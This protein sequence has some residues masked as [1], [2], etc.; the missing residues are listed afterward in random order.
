MVYIKSKNVC[1]DKFEWPN[2][3]G[4]I[5]TNFVS[6]YSATDSCASVGK[7]LCTASEWKEASG[8]KINKYPYGKN[9]SRRKCNTESGKRSGSGKYSQCRSYYGTYDMV[10][11]LSEWTSTED[12]NNP[13]FYRVYGGNSSSTSTATNK[14][15]KFSYYPRNKHVGVGFRCCKKN[16]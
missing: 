9:Y 7:R 2:K 12:E 13:D 16:K 3:R 1:I 8:S 4:E 5:P 14:S 15:F 6:Q 10:G 11:N